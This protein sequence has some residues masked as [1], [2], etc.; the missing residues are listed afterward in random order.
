MKKQNLILTI[1]FTVLINVPF[2]GQITSKEVDKLVENALKKFDIAGV[3]V[4]IVKDGKII[5]SKG[6]GLK[7]IKTKKKVNEH[8]LFAIASNSKAFTAAALSILVDEGKLS[9]QD[10]VKKHIPEFKMYNSYVTENFTIQDLL[11]HRS[12]LGLGAGDLTFFPHG[13]DFTIKDIL[14]IFQH[15]KPQS[16]FRTKF[17]YDNLLYIVAGEV[18]KRISGKSWESFVAE[19]I[20]APLNMENS[21]TSLTYIEDKS[22]VAAPHLNVDGTLTIIEPD[23]FVPGTLN[24]AAGAIM[25]NVNDLSNWMLMHLN[26]GKYGPDLEKKLLKEGLERLDKSNNISTEERFVALC[27]KIHIL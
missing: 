3:A 7:S 10:Q 20:M 19:R 11:T 2:Y 23:V 25:S 17:D 18:I 16:A 6:Y 14:T 21:Y 1:L 15:F 26:K 27:E 8:T 24:G 22:N 12:G 9:W 5:H 4:G 13:S